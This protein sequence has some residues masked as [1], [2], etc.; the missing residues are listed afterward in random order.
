M[1]KLTD[2]RKAELR[3]EFAYVIERYIEKQW[4]DGEVIDSICKNGTEKEYL[5]ESPWWIEVMP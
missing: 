1:T 3:S 5:K 2:E 4:I